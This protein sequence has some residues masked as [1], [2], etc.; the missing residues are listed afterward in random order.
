MKRPPL[1]IEDTIKLH[2]RARQENKILLFKVSYQQLSN[3]CYSWKMS[4][5]LEGD[6]RIS[7]NSHCRV[8]LLAGEKMSGMGG[9]DTIG[10]GLDVGSQLGWEI[11]QVG[12]ADL[13]T[14]L[15]KPQNYEMI[16]QILDGTLQ[17][18]EPV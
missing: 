7:Q 18:L 4:N 6:I 5:E 9:N 17:I 15:D 8:Q 2:L 12:K 16:K 10:F 1:N 14:Y 13:L 11:V 3:L